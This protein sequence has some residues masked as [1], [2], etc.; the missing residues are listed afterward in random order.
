MSFLLT[1]HNYHCD[2]EK[3]AMEKSK[4][5]YRVVYARTNAMRRWRGFTLME[6]LVV[7][8]IVALLMSILMPSLNKAKE[9]ARKVVCM[10]NLRNVMLVYQY[11][12]NDNRD[13]LPYPRYNTHIPNVL[14]WGNIISNESG[15]LL[16]FAGA[17]MIPYIKGGG[18]MFF[19]PSADY[20]MHSKKELWPDM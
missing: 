9:Q 3:K 15:E 17:R 14:H 16:Q 10:S 2:L 5:R 18:E 12:S 4:K 1:T 7:I 8:S 20:F 19:C 11:Y 6:L 13:W